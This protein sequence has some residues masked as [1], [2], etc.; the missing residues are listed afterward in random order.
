MRLLHTADWHLG[1]AFHGASLIDHQAAFLDWLAELADEERIDGVLV[2]GDL[3]DRALPPA[4][5]VALAGEALQRL[6]DHGRQVVVIPGNHDSAL[7]LGFASALL[8]RAG[9]HLR[10]DPLQSA[11][12]VMVGVDRGLRDPVSGARAGRRLPRLPGAHA[13]RGCCTAAMER[14]RADLADRPQGT[15][16]VV[17]AHAFVAGATPVDSERELGREA[18]PRSARGFSQARTTSRS[19]ICTVRR[20]S[21]VVATPARR[22]PTRSRRQPT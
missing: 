5:A 16:C 6:A 7:R 15:A 17:L 9:L 8:S 3:Y 2:A 12:P 11:R 13:T 21:P 22:W 4:D 20:R 10:T 14:V 19:G 1:R 18:R